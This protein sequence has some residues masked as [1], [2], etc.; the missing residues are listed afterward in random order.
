MTNKEILKQSGIYA[1]YKLTYGYDE[2]VIDVKSE[3]LDRAR[4]TDVWNIQSNIVEIDRKICELQTKL[5]NLLTFLNVE[6]HT[7]PTKTY[8]RKKKD[9]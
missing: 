4:N 2:K 5:D 3:L 1:K 8:I 6:Q 9:A 7:E